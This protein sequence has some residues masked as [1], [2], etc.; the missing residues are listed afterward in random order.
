[1]ATWES[2]EA[3]SRMFTKSINKNK[4]NCIAL[5]KNYRKCVHGF[6]LADSCLGTVWRTLGLGAYRSAPD[7]ILCAVTG[8]DPG[9]LEQGVH[10]LKKGTLGGAQPP[11]ASADKAR[12]TWGELPQKYLKIQVVICVFLASGNNH[13]FPSCKK[14]G[15][16]CAMNE[17][18]FG[19]TFWFENC[20]LLQ[21]SALSAGKRALSGGSGCS[22]P[23]TPLDPPMRWRRERALR[24]LIS[25]G[26]D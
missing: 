11:L 19:E 6:R 20:T 15:F 12:S 16:F 2:P 1:M 25:S 4:N 23:A 24:S 9:F 21:K 5:Q 3:M 18:L 7:N 17:C 8:A 26:W 22:P 14:A 10:P 13:V